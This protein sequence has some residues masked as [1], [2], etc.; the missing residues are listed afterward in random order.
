MYCKQFLSN[1]CS[2]KHTVK[3]KRKTHVVPW[4]FFGGVFGSIYKFCFLGYVDVFSHLNTSKILS[5]III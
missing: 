1:E 4:Y 2:L 3:C 5:R